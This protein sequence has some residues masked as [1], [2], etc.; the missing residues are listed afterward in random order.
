MST[1][2]FS[3]HIAGGET[4]AN[5]F[6]LPQPQHLTIVSLPFHISDL[7]SEYELV[8]GFMNFPSTAKFHVVR[9]LNSYP[10]DGAQRKIKNRIR[11]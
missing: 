6:D 2:N 11:M 5:T 3:H 8:D 7:G 9:S 1:Y 4:R 10:G